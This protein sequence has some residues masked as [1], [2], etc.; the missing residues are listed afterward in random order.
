MGK[1]Y[2]EREDKSIQQ[3]LGIVEEDF[4]NE[5]C[6]GFAEVYREYSA[7]AHL[8]YADRNER[9]TKKLEDDVRRGCFTLLGQLD[10][11][12]IRHGIGVLLALKNF[13][14]YIGKVHPLDMF[15][16]LPAHN[17]LRIKSGF[18]YGRFI[19]E[20]R[21]AFTL[22]QKRGVPHSNRDFLYVLL[23]G[24]IV[25]L[26]CAV[27]GSVWKVAESLLESQF[28]RLGLDIELTA[29]G[30]REWWDN[31]LAKMPLNKFKKLG[32]VLSRNM[33]AFLMRYPNSYLI[34]KRLDEFRRSKNI[35]RKASIK[36]AGAWKDLSAGD[37]TRVYFKELRKE[38]SQLERF[39]HRAD[40]T[41]LG[42]ALKYSEPH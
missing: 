25:Y 9:Q 30:M 8:Y 42:L 38:F 6:D 24:L 16:Y 3:K 5:Y 20:G 19:P 2:C 36:N 37:R 11:L 17:C 10:Q 23:P 7:V 1:S 4:V 12:G 32:G 22:R 13:A 29:E 14:D 33:W 39:A 35:R 27:G 18:K 28:K 26:R 41:A 34:P 40:G 21:H 31:N 15:D